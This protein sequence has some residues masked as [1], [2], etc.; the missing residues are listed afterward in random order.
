MK[1]YTHTVRYQKYQMQYLPHQQHEDF[2]KDQ[3]K[4]KGMFHRNT[5]RKT[6]G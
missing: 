3:T 2:A 5:Q 4:M 6:T 1:Q